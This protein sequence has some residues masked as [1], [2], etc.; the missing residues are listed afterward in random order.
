MYIIIIIIRVLYLRRMKK[1]DWRR[2]NVS[3][4][5]EKTKW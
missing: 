5:P 4:F 2:Y 1:N 3:L